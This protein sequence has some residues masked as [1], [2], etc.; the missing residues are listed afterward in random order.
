MKRFILIS[1]AIPFVAIGALLAF[2]VVR[3]PLQIYH[4]NPALRFHG[5]MRV[6]AKGIIATNA[7]NVSGIII[8]TSML[9]NTDP[10][11]A[12]QKLG[13][14]WLNLSL[15]GGRG[16]ERAIVLNYA[17]RHLQLRHVVYSFDL[18]NGYI[19]A[20]V[21]AKFPKFDFLYDGNELNDIRIYLNEKFILCAIDPAWR[22]CSK[23]AKLDKLTF[24]HTNKEHSARF[25]GWQNWVKNKNNVQ[26]RD[27]FAQL[28][29]LP[30]A[31][32]YKPLADKSNLTQTQE[33]YERYFFDLA[34][35][36]P[37]TRFEVIVPTYSRLWWR[38]QP[39]G[40]NA[41]RL[42]VLRWFVERA[43]AFGNV[44][45]YGFDD[46][47]YADDIAHY[48]DETHYNID[49]NARHL[50]AIAGGWGRLDAANI[51]GYIAQVNEKIAAYDLQKMIDLA[52]AAK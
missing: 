16:D 47:E 49:M 31:T 39:A 3:D 18:T 15:S 24:W 13:G 9:E 14:K 28:Q 36:N 40:Q 32:P 35:Q 29:K 48:R 51:A 17:L 2:L 7:A 4:A 23:T 44:R 43:G 52:K 30:R 46:T 26:L 25:G 20:K 27:T 34:A 1:L 8:G 10:R 33:F 5:D 21:G 42:A 41:R 38:I 11:I 22:E 50:D 12:A 45:V 37:Q 19:N 6:Q